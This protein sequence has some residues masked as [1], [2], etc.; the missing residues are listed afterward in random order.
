LIY[1]V[2]NSHSKEQRVSV[3]CSYYQSEF[4]CCFKDD[5]YV[6]QISS[7]MTLS[8]AI[9]TTISSG[10]RLPIGAAE[11]DKVPYWKQWSTWTCRL[12]F[13]EYCDRCTL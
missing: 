9:R 1:S 10:L 13:Q 8:Q 2:I 6:Y 12:L 5:R 11:L 3:F 4:Y 7:Y